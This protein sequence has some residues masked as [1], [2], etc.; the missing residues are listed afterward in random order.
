MAYQYR[1]S[2]SM[3]VKFQRGP[4]WCITYEPKMASVSWK[5]T[6][7]QP[8][9]K[10]FRY[11]S[12]AQMGCGITRDASV[13]RIHSRGPFWPKVVLDPRFDCSSHYNSFATYF[14]HL[15]HYRGHFCTKYT[16]E[17]IAGEDAGW[18]GIFWAYM[19]HH[20]ASYMSQQWK[21]SIFA[22]EGWFLDQISRE[23][24][25]WC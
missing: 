19:A 22:D 25:W 5:N 14:R 23:I 6:S 4:C 3:K 1:L 8:P 12:D 11:W 21:C 16:D 9:E 18:S 7:A 17:S 20:H 15:V 24:H 13:S 2:V 10:L